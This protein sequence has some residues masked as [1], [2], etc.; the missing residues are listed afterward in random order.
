MKLSKTEAVNDFIQELVKVAQE[1]GNQFRAKYNR[2]PTEA[3][4]QE[5]AQM[6]ER[7][8]KLA[9]ACVR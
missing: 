4:A 7:Q 5:M 2:E 1:Q 8:A 3:E 6:I 9:V